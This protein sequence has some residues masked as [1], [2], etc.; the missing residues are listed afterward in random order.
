MNF[1]GVMLYVMVKRTGS[2][3]GYFLLLRS[4]VPGLTVCAADRPVDDRRTR[5]VPERERRRLIAVGAAGGA[6]AVL[7]HS[8]GEFN[9]KIPANGLYFVTLLGLIA[10]GCK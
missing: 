3:D 10:E 2:A 1:L 6:G 7:W 5:P 4:D 8:G 9:W